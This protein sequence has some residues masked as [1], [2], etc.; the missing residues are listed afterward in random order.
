MP[1]FGFRT[2]ADAV[3]ATEAEAE[4][5]IFAGGSRETLVEGKF[6]G[7]KHLQAKI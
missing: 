5:D 2:K 1:E 3:L 7:G 6:L 4:V